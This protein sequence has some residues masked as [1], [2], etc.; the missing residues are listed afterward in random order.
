MNDSQPTRILLLGF[1]TGEESDL[2]NLFRN[3]GGQNKSNVFEGDKPSPN[4]AQLSLATAIF[5][6]AVPSHC[7]VVTAAN[8]NDALDMVQKAVAEG[9]SF[10]V[11]LVN[12][13]PA[14]EG[15]GLKSVQWLMAADAHLSL[16]ACTEDASKFSADLSSAGEAFDRLIFL[17]KPFVMVEAK[18]LVRS[19][20]TARHLVKPD[21][22]PGFAV[23]AV[24]PHIDLARVSEN[25]YQLLFEQSPTPMYIYD[26]ESH[27][28]LAVNRAAVTYYGYTDAEFA[29]LTLRDLMSPMEW[30]SFQTRLSQLTGNGGN[31]GIWTHRRKNGKTGEMAITALALD[32]RGQKAWISLALDVSDRLSL[33][34]Q[35]RQSQKMESIGMLAGGVAH[36]FNNL[37]TVIQGHAGLAA[38]TPNLPPKVGDSLREITHASKRAADL[39]RQL[40][41]FSRKQ[42]IQPSIVNINEII[43]NITKMLRR[44]MGED[45]T[46]ESSLM[47]ELPA[48]MADVGMME[49]VLLNMAVNSRDAMPRGGK[50]RVST[51]PTEV[52]PEDAARNSE[53]AA[54]NHVVLAFE[55]SG[56]GI[57]PENLPRI[58]EPF[59]TTKELDRGTGL[60]LATVYGIVKQHHGWIEVTSQI[61]KGTAFCIFLPVASHSQPS[62]IATGG[63]ALP[64]IG[65][66]ET[67]L[68]VEDEE[69]LLKLMRHVLE[70]YGYKVHGCMTGREALELWENHRQK[71]ELVLTDMVLPDGMAG[72]ELAEILKASKPSL[73][74]IY[75]SG[76]DSG[77]FQAQ[78]PDV[79][80]G[81]FIRKPFHARTLAEKVHE[82]LAKKLQ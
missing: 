48:V 26:R 10:D 69:P 27:K 76:Y 4:P 65:G 14:P 25:D 8:L 71:I 56:C 23:S 46:L 6:P 16:I 41:T 63:V 33:E 62:A 38:T 35:L 20:I 7:H 45:I 21:S 17:R 58:F 30:P 77:K 79:L 73:K 12:I 24:V 34:A 80:E 1:T 31:A 18:H 57:S 53:S 72:P 39:T 49:Q 32:F 74:I 61:G 82:C 15:E 3:L 50:L 64:A 67:I 37:L 68:V 5:S 51:F 52:S 54:G 2:N 81:N 55:D 19:A 47:P 22:A 28:F 42:P 66:T 60:G 29:G 9:R 44:V 13:K 11:A 75:T 70:S 40:Q 43:T 59:F 36:D 78:S